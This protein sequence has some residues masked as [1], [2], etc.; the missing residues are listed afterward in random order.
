MGQESA[1]PDRKW[2]SKQLDGHQSFCNYIL[3]PT[4]ILKELDT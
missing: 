1:V 4:D 3:F 2:V